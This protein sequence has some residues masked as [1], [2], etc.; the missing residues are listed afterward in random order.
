MSKT[1]D[2]KCTVDDL[3]VFN[4]ITNALEIVYKKL[5]PNA[6]E[7]TYAHEADACLDL[8]ALENGELK[9][10]HNAYAYIEYR[11]GLAI[12]IPEGYVGLI[13]PRSSLSN[14]T[15]ILSNSVGVIDSGYTGEIRFRF[16]ILEIP[17]F[18][19][20]TVYKA[21]DKI[22]QIMVIPRPKLILKEVSELPQSERG[23]SG[24]GSTG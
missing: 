2:L 20:G 3:P 7:P 23:A 5:D 21:G 14:T 19:G 8:Y 6:K 1:V 12:S 10:E 13:F 22:G 4:V 15:L 24:F 9:A 18:D 11:T 16:K 17:K